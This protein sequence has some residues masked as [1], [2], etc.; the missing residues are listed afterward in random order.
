MS[1]RLLRLYLEYRHEQD[2][3][4]QPPVTFAAWVE[5]WTDEQRR[6]AAKVGGAAAAAISSVAR[7]RGAEGRTVG[8][9]V[10]SSLSFDAIGRRCRTTSFFRSFFR[11]FVLSF[12]RSLIDALGHRG[13]H[14]RV[15]TTRKQGAPK[16][17]SPGRH[18]CV[19]HQRAHGAVECIPLSPSLSCLVPPCAALRCPAARGKVREWRQKKAALSAAKKADR[20]RMAPASEVTKMMNDLVKGLQFEVRIRYI[21]V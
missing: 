14:G 16:R 5:R 7:E 18:V 15:A 13:L 1:T 21:S 19:S 6:D 10:V 9:V 11:S 3:E 17:P 8:V 12:F 4:A 20:E 2:R